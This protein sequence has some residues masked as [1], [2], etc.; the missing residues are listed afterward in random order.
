MTVSQLLPVSGMNLLSWGHKSPQSGSSKASTVSLENGLP[1]RAV[2][3][4]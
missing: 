4:T 1:Q 3:G 2:Y